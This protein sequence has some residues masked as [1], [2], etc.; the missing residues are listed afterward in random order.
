MKYKN[1]APWLYQ[2]KPF[3]S[4]PE[5]A[6]GF[7]Y[8]I[9]RTDSGR[10]YIGKKAF[11]H[12]QTRP[13]LSGGTRRRVTHKESDWHTYFGSCDELHRDIAVVGVERFEREILCICA[14][15]REHTYAEVERQVKADVLSTK[16]PSGDWAFYNANIMNR[17]FR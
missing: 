7:I 16:L 15:R 8:L 17:F 13:A 9:R 5:G 6:Y 4:A 11:W 1:A 10:S 3:T 2:G 12:K 14:T